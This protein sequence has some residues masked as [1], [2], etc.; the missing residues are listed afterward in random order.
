MGVS[1]LTA[2]QNS[3]EF[4]YELK[5]SALYYEANRPNF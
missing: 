1:K 5:Y 3:M 4:Q 2:Q